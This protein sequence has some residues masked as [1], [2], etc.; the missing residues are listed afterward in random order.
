MNLTD[1]LNDE[2]KRASIIEDV[3]AHGDEVSIL[4]GSTPVAGNRS[5]QQLI[6][7]V[8]H[9]SPGQNFLPHTA[10]SLPAAHRL[11]GG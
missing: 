6:D 10:C 5:G 1:V 9:V 2:A 4:A 11:A 3:R 8:V 7:Q